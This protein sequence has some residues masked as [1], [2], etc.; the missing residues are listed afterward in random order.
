M[1]SVLA[2]SRVPQLPLT[3]PGRLCV[4]EFLWVK[5]APTDEPL[6]LICQ[7][8][9][10]L[11]GAL[12]LFIISFPGERKKKTP[13]VTSRY[14]WMPLRSEREGEIKSKT[15][16]GRR[17]ADHR[18]EPLSG[19]QHDLVWRHFNKR[20]QEVA[21]PLLIWPAMNLSL[22]EAWQR[23][24]QRPVRPPAAAGHVCLMWGCEFA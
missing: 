1:V 12:S 6:L 24:Q 18:W 2:L 22:L 23:R 11:S 20:G 19:K 7:S 21:S 3:C 9:S 10:L 8:A 4:S 5:E 13:R 15:E 14:I 17:R 16:Q